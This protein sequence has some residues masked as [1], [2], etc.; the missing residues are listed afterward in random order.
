MMRYA[1]LVLLLLALVSCASADRHRQIAESAAA[2]MQS[3]GVDPA[4]ATPEQWDTYIQKAIDAQRG[5]WF[6]TILGTTFPQLAG[7]WTLI[8]TLL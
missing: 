8:A 1:V 3:D 6:E 5:S 4:A 7:V 2:M